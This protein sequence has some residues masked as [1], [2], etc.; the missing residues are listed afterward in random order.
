MKLIKNLSQNTHLVNRYTDFK[1][2][3]L[4][5]LT[6]CLT[7]IF[8]ACGDSGNKSHDDEDLETGT[9][10]TV[11][12]YMVAQNN[13]SSYSSSDINEMI[14]AARQGD[15]G[16]S[17]LIV[18]LHSN[19]ESPALYEITSEGRQLLLEYDTSVMSVS[20]ERLSTVIKDT[21]RV[22]PARHY[23]IIFWG[24]GTGYVQDGIDEPGI[25][26]MPTEHTDINTLSY[27]GESINRISYWMNTTT[28]AQTLDGK[29][30]DWIYFDC[31]FMAGVE[32]AYQLRHAVPAIVASATELPAQ[33]TSYNTMLKHVMP[34]RSDLVAAAKATYDYYNSQSGYMRTCTM[35]VINTAQLDNL[36]SLVRS[37]YSSGVMVPE[38][39][40]PQQY[41]LPADNRRYGWAYYDLKHY[42]TALAAEDK[43]LVNNINQAFDNTVQAAFATPLLWNSL[44]IENHNGLSTLIIESIDDPNIEKFNYDQLDWWKDVVSLRFTSQHS[45]VTRSNSKYYPAYNVTTTGSGTGVA[46]TE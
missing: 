42:L 12:V 1:K 13:L 4:I 20:A 3:L 23:G 10:R 40:A 44:P 30:L 11:L 15:L 6:L 32:V 36:A 25:K 5:L 14:T 24:H 29:G 31:C 16:K 45:Y 46:R 2:Q 19:T 22:A 27:G 7:V 39:Y 41:Q 34:E 18:Y 26:S 21:K 37:I 33:G 28:M 17:R 8:T 9:P 38:G 43:D 35:S